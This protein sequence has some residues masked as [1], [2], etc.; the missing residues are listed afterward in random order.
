MAV[1]WGTALEIAMLGIQEAA[2]TVPT[3]GGA[4]H[5]TA[6]ISAL[7][8]AGQVASQVIT[9][10]TQQA[11]AAAAYAAAGSLIKLVFAFTKKK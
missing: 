1:N 10:P 11:E 7:N 2:A 3:F 8:A 5:E 6:A 9:D 4:D